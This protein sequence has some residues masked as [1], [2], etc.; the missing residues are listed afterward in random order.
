MGKQITAHLAVEMVARSI[1]NL[2][3]SLE[4]RKSSC[5]E[6]AMVQEIEMEPW[7]QKETNW[8]QMMEEQ[9]L[10]SRMLPKVAQKWTLNLVHKTGRQSPHLMAG[11]T[12]AYLSLEKTA[13]DW[14]TVLAQ[15]KEESSATS[16]WSPEK[17][18]M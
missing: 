5:W 4:L 14:K 16:E 11:M 2:A 8:G 7:Q 6:V 3:H 18:E 10:A 12:V 13:S 15:L 9:H 1:L 17:A